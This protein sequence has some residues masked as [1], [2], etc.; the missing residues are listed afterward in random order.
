MM[1]PFFD[2]SRLYDAAYPFILAQQS[3]LPSLW[4]EASE[5]EPLTLLKFVGGILCVIFVFVYLNHRYQRWKRYNEFVTEMKTLDL[6][7]DSEGTLA[8]M[9]RRYSMNEPV[10][11]LCSPRLF[12]EMATHEMMRVLSS[13]GSMKAKQEFID[14]VY[15]IRKK[16][17]H[18][19]WINGT[20]LKKNI[21]IS[22]ELSET[23]S[24]NKSNNG[25]NES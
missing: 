8:G 15:K 14:T 4:K 13:S 18:P 6:D 5:V 21:P 2:P 16:T 9:V 3:D 24:G 10:N 23:Y 20:G 12:D 22:T 11:V 1:N 25:N 19:D 17:Y 7:P